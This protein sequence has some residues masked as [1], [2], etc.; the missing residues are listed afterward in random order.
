MASKTRNRFDLIR[1]LDRLESEI[2][3]AEGRRS[4][5][6]PTT[7]PPA[8]YRGGPEVACRASG[9]EPSVQPDPRLVAESD[10]D[11]LSILYRHLLK[12]GIFTSEDDL[13]QQLLALIETYNQTANPFKWTYTFRGVTPT[14][15]TL[16][17]K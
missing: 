17:P 10:R 4:S 5:W 8:R 13:V 14:I 7:S 9:L 16:L 12:H 6:S 11:L 2:P 1:F 15:G 3:I